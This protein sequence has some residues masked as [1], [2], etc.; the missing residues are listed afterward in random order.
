M[1]IGIQPT[2]IREIGDLKFMLREERPRHACS[3]LLSSVP[4]HEEQPLCSLLCPTRGDFL[5]ETF[6]FRVDLFVCILHKPTVLK[7]LN[8]FRRGVLPDWKEFEC[9]LSAIYNLAIL[10]LNENECATHLDESREALL[11]RFRSDV[12]RGLDR[13]SLTTTHKVSALQTLLLHIVSL[14]WSLTTRLLLTLPL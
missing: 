9:Q 13:L 5:T 11:A 14:L 7:Q 6:M 4:N 2:N 12:E 3:L 1:H 8:H 10:S